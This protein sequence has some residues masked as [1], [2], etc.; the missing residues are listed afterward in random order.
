MAV[1]LEGMVDGSE[2]AAL[3][4][5]CLPKLLFHQNGIRKRGARFAIQQRLAMLRRNQLQQLLN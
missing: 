1:L 4:M 3:M 5:Q 2:A